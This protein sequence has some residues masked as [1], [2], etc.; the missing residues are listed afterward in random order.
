MNFFTKAV[1][2]AVTV[3]MLPFQSLLAYDKGDFI[4]RAGWARVNPSVESGIFDRFPGAQ[5]EVDSSD[6]LGLTFTYMLSDSIGLGVLAAYPF[7]FDI[8]GAGSITA[9][10]KIADVKA[11]PPTVTLQ[12]HM[13]TGS[14][15]HP[16]V[17]A[18]FNYTT[19]W[20]ESTS[21]APFTG[22][23]LSLD[24]SWGLALEAGI[25]YDLGNGLLISAQAWY[26]QI[27]TEADSAAAGL[28]D[29]E[30][31]PF[32]FMLGIGKKF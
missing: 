14:K 28:A 12:Y 9:V 31:D 21:D 27:E 30:L 16:Y 5:A 19:F 3:L 20:N 8:A 2:I 23:A 22:T 10:K 26:I 11:L 32:V 29:V 18:G 24:D 6:S 13:N 17:G 4:A 7:E 15:F 25:D 1:L